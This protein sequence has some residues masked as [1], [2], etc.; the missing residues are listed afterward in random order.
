MPTLPDLEAWA[1]FA[2]VLETGSFAKAAD[3]LGIS[4]PTVSKAISR[5]EH[6]LG[7]ALLYRNSRQLSLTPTGEVA[8]ARAIRI[9]SE[10]EAVEA[11]TSAQV[12][13][14]RGMVRITAP[15]SFGIRYFAPLIP[16]FLER[17]PEVE[18]DLVL[19]D[20]IV[21]VVAGGFDMAI[22]IAE[23]P[24]SSLRSRRLCVVNRP[25]VATPAYLER[26]GRPAHPRDLAHHACLIYTNLPTPELWQFQHVVSGEKCAVPVKGR[27][28]SNNADVIGPALLAAQGLA[29]QPEFI[30]WDALTRGELID[31]FPDWRISQIN[32]NLVTP[33]NI[34]RPA[35]VTA[36]LDYLAE[37]LAS[38][39]WA[40]V[41]P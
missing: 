12:I 31:V 26:H 17:Y 32:V 8:K 19:T 10:G 41:V 25:L 20:Q 27:I 35:R 21:D 15:M 11:E 36:L 33:P 1:I 28:R 38:A 34:L 3:S 24:D 30:V 37:C 29:L 23:L 13:Q 4:Q 7:T 5:L 40:T 2:R 9:L 14:P 16:A 39:P 22:R 18:I 6:R